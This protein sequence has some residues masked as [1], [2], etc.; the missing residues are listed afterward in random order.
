MKLEKLIDAV[1]QGRIKDALLL[2]ED[3]DWLSVNQSAKD[4][5]LRALTAISM[6]SELLDYVGKLSEARLRLQGIEKIAEEHIRNLVENKIGLPPSM[7]SRRH[8]K[9]WVWVLMQAAIAHYRAMTLDRAR[10]LLDLCEK[11]VLDFVRTLPDYPCYGTLS[12]LNYSIGLVYRE[13]FDYQNA[14]E[15]F[16]MSIEFAWLSLRQKRESHPAGVFLPPFWTDLAIARA[17]ALGL[18]FVY[19]SEGQ[20]DL[21]LSVLLSAKNLL[22]RLDEKIIS[23]YVDLIYFDARRSAFGGDAGIVDESIRGLLACRDVFVDLNHQLYRARADYSLALAFSQRARQDESVPLSLRGQEDLRLA[24]SYAGELADYG[25]NNDDWRALLNAQLCQS[26]IQRKQNNFVLAE[27]LATQ[28]IAATDMHPRLRVGALIARAEAFARQQKTELAILDFQEAKERS[29]SSLR[30]RAICL[31]RLAEIYARTK[32]AQL[33]TECLDEW[34][35]TSPIISNAY[36]RSL[37]RTALVAVDNAS[38][39]FVIRMSDGDV[40]PKVLEDRLRKFMVEWAYRRIKKGDGDEAAAAL[41]GVTRQTLLNWK[42]G[43]RN[44]VRQ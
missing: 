35:K 21:A 25:R 5:E 31:L 16:L 41:L 20:A 18:G 29:G 2:A 34:N 6:S 9:R 43:P 13:G 32:R 44:T 42:K 12:R 19:H 22:V 37:E 27:Q 14:K 11:A 3:V 15:R 7:S 10:M 38:E 40:R 23:T 4:G 1:Q 39:D 24:T 17:Q 30:T 33:A 36:I 8:L 26:R 28:I